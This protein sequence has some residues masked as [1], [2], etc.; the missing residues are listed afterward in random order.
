VVPTA[1]YMMGGV[2]FSPDT[3]TPLPALFAAGE[4]TGGVHGANRLG[5]NGVANSTVFGGIAG[6]AMAAW[7]RRE[8]SFRAPDEQAIAA[9][10]ARAEAPF[11]QPAGDIEAVR[12][13]LFECMWADV[14]ILRTAES[15]QRGLRRLEELDAQ[16][17]RTGVAPID[18][19]FHV[20]WHDWLNLKNLV[21]V[22]RVIAMSALARE[23]SRGAHFREDFPDTGDLHS[24]HTIV[25]R[26]GASG[27]QLKRE[28]V[29]F[30]RVAPGH[31]LLAAA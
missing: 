15:L 2:V 12:E 27:L 4:D 18:R 26:Q 7:V 8:G 30:T 21:A 19:A 16:L 23:D 22:S 3:R 6:D 31:S 9:A 29:R 13:A 28:P 5:G 1:H 20:G 24:S 11:A 10:V 17:A 14:G 25:V